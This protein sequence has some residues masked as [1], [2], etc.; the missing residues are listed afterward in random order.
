MEWVE[1]NEPHVTHTHTGT[2]PWTI[3]EPARDSTGASVTCEH[4][5]MLEVVAVMR[6]WQMGLEMVSVTAAIVARRTW[7][8][9]SVAR[10][11]ATT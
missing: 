1:R 7:Y 6:R 2:L 5:M 4:L 3:G 10:G 9:Q 8:I 11:V